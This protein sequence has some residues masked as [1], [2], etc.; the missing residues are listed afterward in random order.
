[1]FVQLRAHV[2]ILNSRF[3]SLY[4]YAMIFRIFTYLIGLLFVSAGIGNPECHA[5]FTDVSELLDASGT[6]PPL[7]YGGGVSFYD[8]NGDGWDDLSVVGGSN[9]PE[10]FLN[11]NGVLEP[12]DLGIVSE[13]SAFVQAMLWVDYDNDGDGDLFISK[14]GAPLELWQNDGNLN[15]VNVASAAGL[16]QGVYKYANAAFGDYDHDGCLDLMVAKY[17]TASGNPEP[18]YASVL[19]HS[20]C[21]G[22]FSNVTVEAGVYLEPRMLLQ[23][24]FVDVNNDG[25]EDLFWAMD[26]DIFQNELFLNNQDGTFTR[27]SEDSGINHFVC[28]MSATIGDYDQNGFLD[29]YVSN[30]PLQTGN[31]LFRN[32]GDTTFSDK[33]VQLGVNIFKSCWGSMWLDFDNDSWEDLYVNT[34][35]ISGEPVAPNKMF[36]NE[37]GQNFTDGSDL[38]GLTAEPLDSYTCAKGDLNNDGYYDFATNNKVPYTP[39]LF[40]NNGG[41]NHYLSVS[42]EGTLANKD[43]IGTWIHC[44]F[45]GQHLVQ[46]TMC[47]ESLSGQHS[48]KEIFGLGTYSNIDSL[49][50]QWNSGTTEVYYDLQTDAHHH[51]VEGASLTEPVSIEY[52]GNLNLCPGDSITLDAGDYASYLWNNGHEGQM[53]TIYEPGTYQVTVTNDFGF[54]I[55]SSPID[56]F[57][58]PV[59]DFSF[60]IEHVSCS[61][62]SDGEILLQVDNTTVNSINWNSGETTLFLDSL[63]PGLY[64][65]TAID[66]SGCAFS[67]AVSVNEPSPLLAQVLTESVNCYGEMNGTASVEVLGGTPPYSTNWFG[68]TPDSLAAAEYT[69][70]VSDDNSCAT[71]LQFSINEPDSLWLELTIEDI[72]ADNDYGTAFAAAQGGTPPYTVDWSTGSSGVWSADSLESG[73]YSVSVTD[74]NG[75]NTYLTFS[76]TN[77]TDVANRS[78]S[79]LIVFP[80]PTSDLIHIDHCSTPSIA[81]RMFDFTGREVRQASRY[82]CPAEISLGNLRSG[83][84]LLEI[85]SGDFVE[86]FRIVVR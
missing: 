65:F 77:S 59:P 7:S 81:A 20:N 56:I 6:N 26:R 10:F 12:I 40:Q 25:W 5:Q 35:A 38:L 43:G 16:E 27:V 70:V 52:N 15:F 71:E 11:N 60:D 69:V 50:L 21:D 30:N 74:D 47:G 46:Y 39:R 54:A 19:Y 61:G 24:A 73:S 83:T 9:D 84:Y 32:N 66:S 31:L 45:N 62:S 75:C 80:N 58:A 17:Y 51:L 23:P 86:Y 18:E 41:N 55:Q 78:V 57:V 49:V 72:N 68:L 13:G 3:N 4:L 28:A 48:S 22:T 36:I 37:Q 63:V 67:G 33:A 1:M 44:Y 14:Q 64:E 79:D 42:L 76:I 85:E 8:F 53:L 29:I 34:I 82:Y 2:D